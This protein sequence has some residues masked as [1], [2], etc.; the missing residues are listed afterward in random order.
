MLERM[1]HSD[2]LGAIYPPM[3]YSIMALDVL[4]YAAGSSGARGSHAAVRKPDGGRR[5][6]LLLPAL[7]FAG[8]GHGDRR[9]C[10]GRSR[11]PRSPARCSA[12]P[13]GCS[14]DEIRRKGDW[15]VK[16]PDTEPSGWAFE[17]HNDWYPDIDDTAMVLLALQHMR[18]ARTP[19]R[20]RPCDKRALDWLLAMQSKDGGWAAFD[21][22]NNWE[23]PEPRSLRRSQ[24]DARSHLRRYHRPH[25]GSAGGARLRPQPSG[26]ASAAIDYLIR[27]Q[28]ADG[29]WY[30]RWGVA[31]IYGTCFALR[32]LRAHGRETTTKPHIQRANEWLRSIQNADGGWG[33]SCASYDNEAVHAAPRARLRR[34][35]G[36][37]WA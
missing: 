18:A 27:T 20:S 4:G 9:L 24:R 19:R 25:A 36:R 7:L 21:V 23:I 15:S 11:I 5:R 30:G 31:Y 13:T 1:K 3:M 2:G 16:R 17:F 33:E 29:S 28:L 35:P 10:A 22:D 37:C 6:A 14:T 32:G 12:R 8:L 34:P 26:R